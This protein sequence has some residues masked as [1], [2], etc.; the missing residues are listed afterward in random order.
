M[1]KG[2]PFLEILGSILGFSGTFFLTWPLLIQQSPLN[3][4]PPTLYSEQL[5]GLIICTIILLVPFVAVIVAAFV[6]RRRVRWP[7]LIS[8][9]LLSL[10]W[11]QT[12]DLILNFPRVTG[13]FSRS[14]PRSMFPPSIIDFLPAAILLLIAVIFVIKKGSINTISTK[15]IVILGVISILIV[16]VL[17]ASLVVLFHDQSSEVWI[18]AIPNHDRTVPFGEWIQVTDFPISQNMSVPS[19]MAGQSL[20]AGVVNP[21]M[22]KISTLLLALGIILFVILFIIAH[23]YYKKLS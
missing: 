22:A 20:Y 15:R 7:V 16:G 17:S 10:M 2:F 8:S 5:P 13:F 3:D 14:P 18:R 4:R 9:I 11:F 1:R 23:R 21:Q 19:G 6:L 12:S